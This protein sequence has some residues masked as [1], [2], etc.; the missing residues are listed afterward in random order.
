MWMPPIR[1]RG[2]AA[3]VLGALGLLGLGAL[4][5]E[6]GPPALF[7]V[8]PQRVATFEW[9]AFRSGR[10]A[11]EEAE[12]SLDAFVRR[13]RVVLASAA[14]A[15]EPD[16]SRR[17]AALEREVLAGALVE[18]RM[19]AGA[20]PTEEELRAFFER[21]EA[22]RR[23]RHILLKDETA[24]QAALSELKAGRAF[25]AVARAR[26]EDRGS[27]E[28]GGEIGWVRKEQLV[29]PFAREAFSLPAGVV[30]PPVK[31]EYGYHLIEVL[32]IQPADF[33]KYEAQRP[34]ILEAFTA[35][36]RSLLVHLMEQEA[37]GA[38]PVTEKIPVPGA[39]EGT[40]E[41][42]LLDVGGS[43]AVTLGDLE[44]YLRETFG[45]DPSG[46]GMGT[47]VRMDMLKKLAVQYQVAALAQREGMAAR[48]E[49][50]GRIAESRRQAL[51]EEAS[52]RHVAA[53]Q[54]SEAE[55]AAFFEAQKASLAANPEVR[56]AI[57]V[58]ADALRLTALAEA[59]RDGRADFEALVR[60]ESAD[61]ET[62]ER[63]GDLGWLDGATLGNLF[64][65][66]PLAAIL[67][68]PAGAVVG[69]LRTPMGTVLVRVTERR[70]G[71]PLALEAVKAKAVG[72]YRSANADAIV[73]RWADGLSDTFPLR[74]VDRAALGIGGG[75]P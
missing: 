10:P 13:E 43:Q 25:E 54:P 20:A 33:A 66:E 36:R 27:A 37:K 52:A 32:E 58:S 63:G 3:A 22:R 51:F 2:G 40:P 38:I 12:Q 31:T 7:K 41:M 75:G 35:Q 6:G 19:A 60:S 68:A 62:A 69:P 71:P 45:G 59:V 50:Q 21:R 1:R 47:T 57:L 46:H 26:S 18:A 73:A 61:R 34:Q 4:S 15:A 48:P 70:D 14:L 53:Y 23:V 42:V 29:L 72:A 30:S 28:A 74:R 49:V 9:E 64:E 44:A 8:G 39:G 65:G 55:L 5:C 24:A 67:A 16:M 56:L 11:G 17:L